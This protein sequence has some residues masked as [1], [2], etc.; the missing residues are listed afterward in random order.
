M[1]HFIGP[2]GLASSVAAATIPHEAGPLNCFTCP[3][4]QPPELLGFGQLSSQSSG[5][6]PEL[7][8]WT[9][10]CIC[11]LLRLLQSCSMFP[12]FSVKST[13]V[14][15]FL[16]YFDS[17]LS[18]VSM[19]SFV[20]PWCHHVDCSQLCSP[21]VSH[22]P[23]FIL[24]LCFSLSVSRCPLTMLCVSPVFPEISVPSFQ[25]SQSRYYRV[26]SLFL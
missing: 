8:F 23:Q 9:L 19:S 24:A 11:S 7:Y 25:V 17:P 6:P 18:D 12:V 2:H 16:F 21:H 22:F 10:F 20:S 4:G 15:F 14:L 26:F 1:E 5:R 13:S 3:P